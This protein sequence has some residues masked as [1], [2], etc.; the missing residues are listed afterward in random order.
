MLTKKKKLNKTQLTIIIILIVCVWG[1]IGYY[2][3]GLLFKDKRKLDSGGMAF[4]PPSMVN[5]DITFTPNMVTGMMDGQAD[6]IGSPGGRELTSKKQDMEIYTRLTDDP[7]FYEFV[8][9]GEWPIEL[10]NY[11]KANPFI[12]FDNEDEENADDEGVD[13]DSVPTTPSSPG[14]F[15]PP[16]LN[17]FRFPF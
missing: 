4:A 7:R 14:S 8:T 10:G 17:N 13:T 9:Y 15:T 2:L 5:Q 6:V 12:S 1:V 16:D 11:G 3:Y